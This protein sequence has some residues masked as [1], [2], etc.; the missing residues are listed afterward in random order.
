MTNPPQNQQSH[1]VGPSDLGSLV[2]QMICENYRK[3]ICVV[4]AYDHEWQMLAVVSYGTSPQFRDKA[5]AWAEQIGK[6]FNAVARSQDAP[7]VTEDYQ[8]TEQAVLQGRID[9]LVIEVNAKDAR[10]K[11]LEEKLEGKEKLV[12]I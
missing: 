5:H 2:P 10:I 11:A 1:P 4:L 9:Q 3:H 8:A 12:R 6:S 7:I